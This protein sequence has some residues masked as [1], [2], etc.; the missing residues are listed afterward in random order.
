ML[1][2]ISTTF[3]SEELLTKIVAQN[4]DRDFRLLQAT[5]QD[6]Q[7]QLLDISDKPSVF[8]TPIDYH[9]LGHTGS[10]DFVGLF[11]FEFL[12]LAA[13]DQKVWYTAVNHN[14]LNTNLPTGMLA[15][16]LCENKTHS[17]ECLLLT[18]WATSS[19]LDQ[20]IKSDSYRKISIFND[21]QNHFY[22]QNYSIVQ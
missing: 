21:S 1:K 16:Y 3:G 9:L 11:H 14:I 2:Q 17:N 10:K 4:P 13:D 22:Q 20:W 5:P 7:L 15:A 6:N 12:K 18:L 19:G 8:N